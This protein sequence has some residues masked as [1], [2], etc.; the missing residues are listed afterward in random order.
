MRET[1]FFT[2]V[3]FHVEAF[4]IR[5][6]I[7]V[8]MSV[9]VEPQLPQTFRRQTNLIV[10]LKFIRKVG[11]H[12]HIIALAM[13]IPTLKSQDVMFIVDVKNIQELTAQTTG[14]VVPVPAAPNQIS[15]K[16]GDAV[17][18][19]VQIPIQRHIVFEPVAL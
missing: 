18:I 12:D 9:T 2:L 17:K 16:A 15:I 7:T 5:K 8:D 4:G 1:I 10:F 14:L 3:G 13:L 11:N 19:L 6:F